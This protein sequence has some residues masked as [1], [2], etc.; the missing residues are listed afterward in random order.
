VNG[1]A[2]E[3]FAD[4]GIF[5]SVT[6]GN[7]TDVNTKGHTAKDRNQTLIRFSNIFTEIFGSKRD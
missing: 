5:P 4:Q 1:G 3:R 7:N 2:A 6:S